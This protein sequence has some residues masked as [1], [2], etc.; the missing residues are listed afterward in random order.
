VTSGDKMK[1]LSEILKKMGGV[2]IAFSGGVDSTFLA[3]AAKKVLGD[4]VLL[5]TAL[6]PTYPEKEQK[7]A[8]QLAR[9]LGIKQEII[10]S[11]ELKIPGFAENPVNRCYFCKKELFSIVKELAHKK[12]IEVVVDGSNADDLADYR[13]GRKALKELGVRSPLLEAG[14]TKKDIRHFSRKIG[15][16]T[17]DKP[18]MACLASRFPYG[19]KITEKK[20][21]A[22][23]KVEDFLLSKGFRQVRVRHHGEIARIEVEPSEL[24]KILKPGLRE[25]IAN[26][27]RKSGF[28]YVA[29]D[30]EGYRTGSMNETLSS[31][32]KKSNVRAGRRRLKDG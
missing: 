15:L 9:R 1:R 6:S 31:D 28:T 11:N 26:C 2:A 24:E 13:P 14:F 12:G 20:L 16:P 23:D 25:K 29:L 10:V 32:L 4:N 3:A 21:T 7:T 22:V 30:L 19:S 17:A 5:I 18:S 8:R 27:A